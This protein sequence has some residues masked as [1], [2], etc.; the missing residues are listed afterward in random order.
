MSPV[1]GTAESDTVKPERR[2]DPIPIGRTNVDRVIAPRSAAPHAC[3]SRIIP[4]TRSPLPH[5]PGQVVA[6]VRAHT[7]LILGNRRRVPNARFMTIAFCCVDLVT[8]GI[9]ASVRAPRRSHSCSRHQAFGIVPMLR[10]I[11]VLFS[12]PLPSFLRPIRTSPIPIRRDEC[13]VLLIGHRKIID[14][15]IVRNDLS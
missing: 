6:T 1:L 13:L 5:V 4:P 9:H 11:D 15:K 3:L 2:Y 7:I 8:P 10:L 12:F 14:P